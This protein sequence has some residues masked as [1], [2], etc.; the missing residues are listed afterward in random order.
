MAS[1]AF[2]KHCLLIH[3]P[4]PATFAPLLCIILVITKMGLLQYHPSS[5]LKVSQ[6]F[7]SLIGRLT[8]DWGLK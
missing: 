3:N 4:A 6:S 7:S 8:Y 2:S 5:Q 1:L